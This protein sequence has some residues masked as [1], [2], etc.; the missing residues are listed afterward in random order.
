VTLSLRTYLVG[1]SMHGRHKL[2][3][4]VSIAGALVLLFMTVVGRVAG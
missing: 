3:C 4:E 2:I 1:D